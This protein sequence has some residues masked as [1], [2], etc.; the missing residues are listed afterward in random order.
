MLL[1]QIEN[2]DEYSEDFI[3]DGLPKG[4]VRH[5]K[6]QRGKE[7]IIFASTST[8]EE[9]LQAFNSGNQAAFTAVYNLLYPSVFQFAHR[10]LSSEKAEDIT[11]DA[12]CKLWKM[13]KNFARLQSI[14]FFLQVTVR[15][16]SINFLQHK[17]FIEN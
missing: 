3:D 11:A 4:K 14:R 16:A 13:D 15:I 7:E 8:D 12:F 1:E 10:F 5:R 9:N 6:T 2:P 17:V